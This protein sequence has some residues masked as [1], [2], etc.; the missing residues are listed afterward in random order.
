MK[1]PVLNSRTHENIFSDK[2][3][4][5]RVTRASYQDSNLFH[6]NHRV[7]DKTIQQTALSPEPVLNQRDT[8][9]FRSQVFE[10]AAGSGGR[11]RDQNTFKSTVF[12]SATPNPVNR[13]KLGGESKGTDTLFG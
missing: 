7:T 5:D 12:G 6:A 13:K 3:Q 9:T 2:P 8:N 11:K 4:A 10:G 1:N